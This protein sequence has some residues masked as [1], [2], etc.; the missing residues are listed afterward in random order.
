MYQKLCSIFQKDADEQKCNLSY[1]KGTDMSLHINKI[2][3]LAYRLK[4]LTQDINDK[5]I[6]SKILS[7][8]PENHKYFST[9][10]DSTPKTERTLAQ[11]I[12]RLLAEEAKTKENEIESAVAFK[13]SEE[14]R[15][16][17]Q[18]QNKNVKTAEKCFKCGGLGLPLCQI[19]YQK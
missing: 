9:A 7:T 13:T 18:L 14:R 15:N 16:R 10:W 12:S 2:D 8:L 3:N 11:L 1:E 5:M 6:I 4:N 19:M 17:N